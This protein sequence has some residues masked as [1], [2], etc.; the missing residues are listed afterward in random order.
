MITPGNI[1]TFISEIE[2]KLNDN[3]KNKV[4]FA[5]FLEKQMDRFDY[6]NTSLA[7]KVFHRVERKGEVQYIPVTRQTVGAWMKGCMPSSREIYVTLG[8]AFDMSLEEINYVLLENYMGYGL[9]CKNID[10][11]LWIAVVNGLFPVHDFESV[12]EEIEAIF[13]EEDAK[14]HRSVDTMDLWVVLS[15]VQTLEEFYAV[16]RT[17]KTEFKEGARRFGQCLE[18]VIQEEYGYYDKAAWFLRDI[19]CLHC[20]AQFSKIRAGKAI[21]TREWLLRFCI[22]LQPSL[23]SIEKLLAKAQMEP[24]GITP[25][26]TII[27]MIAG[28]K[29]DSLANSQEVW[30]LI[31]SVAQ[32]LTEKGYE[33]NEDLCRKY[34]SVYELPT[35][36]KWWI[37]M[38]IGK[39]MKIMHSM[40]DYGYEK[41]GY[42]RFTS[43]DRVLFDD[44]NRNR[45]NLGFKNAAAD[46]WESKEPWQDY[47]CTEFVNLNIS[48]NNPS[49]P[50]EADKFE[51][52][53][54]LRKPNKFS[55]DFK[56]NDI[57]YYCALLYSIWTGKCYQ[58]D[59]DDS[60]AQILQHEFA[61]QGLDATELIEMLKMNLGE[62]ASYRD[63]HNLD[64]VID[65]VNH[66]K[67]KKQ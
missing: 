6:S 40:K 36:H 4:P 20:E 3:H 39:Q 9:Y 23:E 41:T 62:D 14:D 21:V 32:A 18:E 29:A 13:E 51:D 60:M 35:I 28:Y 27:E 42:A 45:K 34:N 22:A 30:M 65:A 50:L 56:M 19:G 12:K 58:K 26:E 67:I 49:D 48:K 55:K 24:L 64:R 7:R 1:D 33:M 25:V 66:V 8:M 11:A 31:E 54:Y 16:I 47:P 63:S 15:K 46:C 37:S 17:Y 43:V 10:D 38:C 59:F 5:D 57:Y 44:V 52:Y 53:C 2:E 61:L